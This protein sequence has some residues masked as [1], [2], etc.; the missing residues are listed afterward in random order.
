VHPTFA[1]LTLNPSP[2]AL[3]IRQKYIEVLQGKNSGDR[4]C[5]S[6]EHSQP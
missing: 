5:E 2:K 3:S 4:M 1:A 6:K